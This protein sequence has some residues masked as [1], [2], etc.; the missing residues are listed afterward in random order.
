MDKRIRIGKRY[1]GEGEKTFV[2]A[3]VSAN[4]LQDY[5]RAEAIIKAAAQ[6][7]ADA[8]KLQTYTPDTITLD[9]DNDYFQITQGTIWDGTTLH[10]LYEEAYTPWEWQPR[11][12]EY[13]NGLGLECFSSPF[14]ATAVDFMKEMDMPA[15]KVASFEINDIPLIRKIAGLGKPVILATGIAYLEDMERALQVCKEEGNEQVV[16]LKCT[17]A[18][19]SPYEEMNLKVI[20]NMAQVF[21]CITGLSDHSMGTAAAVASVALGAKMVEKHL[22][23]SRADGG[24]DGAF[25]MEPD[26]FKKMVDEIRIVEKALGK[27][28]YEL[29]EK[30]KRSREDGR[31]LFV[32]KNMKEGE[33]FTEENVRSIRPAFGLHTMYLDEIMG[34]RARTD[35]SKGT[36]L[37]WKLIL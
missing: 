6:A 1:V 9:C 5:G 18:Y 19:P 14:D 33:I 24:P 23:L 7:G 15:Y 2:V 29:S 27:V 22:T 13:A 4:H 36:P 30:Q 21:D 3:E 20:P 12:M 26:E 31:S 28:T 10:K 8:V 11:L 25:S 35:I 34:K 17:S 32:V 37:D 16:L